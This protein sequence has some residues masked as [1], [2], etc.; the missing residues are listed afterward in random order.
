MIEI[1]LSKIYNRL[2]KEDL[3]ERACIRAMKWLNNYLFHADGALR[4][5]G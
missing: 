1:F 4:S 5:G 3:P 2:V